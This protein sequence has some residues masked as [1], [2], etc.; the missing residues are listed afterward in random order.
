ML[1]PP[2]PPLTLLFGWKNNQLLLPAGE[3]GSGEVISAH[4]AA[5]QRADRSAAPKRLSPRWQHVKNAI[6]DVE[7]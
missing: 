3:T 5:D 1:P 6:K 2:P 4:I 7:H